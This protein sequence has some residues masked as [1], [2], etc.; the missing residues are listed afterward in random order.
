VAVPLAILCALALAAVGASWFALISAKA[1]VRKADQ[2]TSDLESRTETSLQALQT[3]L[4]ELR[5]EAQDV[6]HQPQVVN[7][8]PAVP[9]PG[10]NLTTRSQVLRLNRRGESV[11]QIAR[12]LTVPRQ[13]VELL[14]KVH[15]IVLGT[16]ETTK[17]HL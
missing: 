10:M 12:I 3:K 17:S 4:E 16:M 1:L 6:T 11:E 2:R 9:R 7:P 8:T 15:R 13:E 14:L 5:A